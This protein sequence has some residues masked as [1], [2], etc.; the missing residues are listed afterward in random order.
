MEL[1][2]FEIAFNRA[3][4]FA[5][6]R[7]KIAVVFPF[8][9]LSSALFTFCQ[10]LSYHTGT[11]LSLS[12]LFVPLLLSVGI[13]LALGIILVRIY[14][15]E[16]KNSVYDI[17]KI[18]SVS[19]D[20][21]AFSAYLSLPILLIYFVLWACLG[22]FLAF[23]SIPAVGK[24]IGALFSFAPFLLILLS[25]A[26]FISSLVL[27]F[28]GVPILALHKQG[29]KE[30]CVFLLKRVMQD[31][32]KVL[33]MFFL[34]M[35]PLAMI[36]LTLT[37]AAYLTSWSYVGDVEGLTFIVSWFL[38]TLPASFLF[39][40]FCVFFFNFAAE[41]HQLLVPQKNS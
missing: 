7:K 34:G 5:F 32:F 11:W 33:G 40:P 26:L 2:D 22:V 6:S 18:L 30:K 14:Y 23:R 31:T 27:L 24:Y 35:L 9:L 1:F 25:I 38:I 3:F 19:W 29:R 20:L 36:L 28:F 17:K 15:H 4:R 41:S 39:T 37:V 12:L 13:F 10:A 16:V 21:M 8:L